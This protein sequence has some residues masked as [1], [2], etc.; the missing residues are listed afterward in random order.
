MEVL[1]KIRNIVQIALLT[2]LGTT[3][4]TYCMLATGA[5]L[6]LQKVGTIVGVGIPTV[7][8]IKDA[9]ESAYTTYTN[10]AADFPNTIK[11][12]PAE[13]EAFYKKLGADVEI[14][15][16]PDDEDNTGHAFNRGKLVVMPEKA[17]TSDGLMTLE[18]AMKSNKPD[19][20]ATFEGVYQHEYQHYLNKDSYRAAAQH[21]VIPI[22]TTAIAATCFKKTFPASKTVAQHAGRCVTKIMAG[23]DLFAGNNEAVKQYAAYASR[24]A[25]FAADKGVSEK[26]KDAFLN[27]VELADAVTFTKAV[28]KHYPKLSEPEQVLKA[29]ELRKQNHKSPYATHPSYEKRRKALGKKQNI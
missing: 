22:A 20:L 2:G 28:K 25:E 5:K 6:V 23:S 17:Y 27:Y 29:A 13:Q 19:A 10:P 3:G 7:P 24:K 11:S 14:K 18:E 1:M 16:A 8:F 26:N 15:Y 4:S 9:A 21:P 12:L